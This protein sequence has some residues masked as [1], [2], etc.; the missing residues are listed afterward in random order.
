MGHKGGRIQDAFQKFSRET[1]EKRADPQTL[2]YHKG[3]KGKGESRTRKLPSSR[4]EGSQSRLEEIGK[5][6]MNG[7]GGTKGEK[8]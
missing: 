4:N 3:G 5:K 1:Q 6:S 2:L 7:K 8:N